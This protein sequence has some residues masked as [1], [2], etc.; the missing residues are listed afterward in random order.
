MIL[1]TYDFWMRMF[2][3]FVREIW[4]FS[5]KHTLNQLKK[6]ESYGKNQKNYNFSTNSSQIS[7]EKEKRK[8]WNQE[9]VEF[10]NKNIDH[11]SVFTQARLI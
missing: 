10:L 11:D 7:T 8:Q 1:L 6:K 2:R 5:E 3:D 9:D 4:R